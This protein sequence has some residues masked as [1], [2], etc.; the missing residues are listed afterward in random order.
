MS[1]NKKKQPPMNRITPGFYGYGEFR[2]VR[3]KG[4]SMMQ[5][6]F[7][8]MRLLSSCAC[9]R[10]LKKQRNRGESCKRMAG[11]CYVCTIGKVVRRRGDSCLAS[12]VRE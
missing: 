6:V 3:R 7:H 8:D 12:P 10:L 2:L 9:M 5:Q 1:K 4:P 11:C